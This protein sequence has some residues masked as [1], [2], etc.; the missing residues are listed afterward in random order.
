LLFISGGED[1]IMPPAVNKSNANHYR[2]SKAITE[3]HEFPDRSHFTC[4]EPGWEAVADYALDWA[5]QHATG[6]RVARSAEPASAV[7]D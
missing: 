5:V 3:Y 6:V 2:K 7:A 4:G 1:H